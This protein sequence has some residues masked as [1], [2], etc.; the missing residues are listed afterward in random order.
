MKENWVKFDSE[1]SDVKKDFPV[2]SEQ[3]MRDITF[4]IYQLNQAVNYVSMLAY[5]VVTI[6]R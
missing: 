2:L 6:F 1:A 5:K 3:Y 4:G